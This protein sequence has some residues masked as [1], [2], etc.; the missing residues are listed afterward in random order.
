MIGR[1]LLVVIGIM[2]LCLPSLAAATESAGPPEVELS[3]TLHFTAPDDSELLA[4][5]ARLRAKNLT[6][7]DDGF[8]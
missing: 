5:E 3:S 1:T 8:L 6:A 4:K 2:S 7:L